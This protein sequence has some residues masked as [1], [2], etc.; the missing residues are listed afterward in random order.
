MSERHTGTAPLKLPARRLAILLAT[1]VPLIAGVVFAVRTYERLRTKRTLTNISTLGQICLVERP[2][3]VDRQS[4]TGLAA[5][6]GAVDESL[7]QDGWGNEIRVIMTRDVSG[8]HYTVFAK[9][10][11]HLPSAKESSGASILPDEAS[12]A[13]FVWRD[14]AWL[15]EYDPRRGTVVEKLPRAGMKD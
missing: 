1:L 11:A 7:F 5:R 12:R 8:T 3:V 9:G 15:R 13:S 2:G 6:L 4:L 10:P 14:G